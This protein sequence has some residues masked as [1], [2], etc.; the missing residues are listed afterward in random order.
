MKASP[1]STCALSQ[2]LKISS[3]LALAIAIL[4]ANAATAALPYC[5]GLFARGIQTFGNNSYV[6]FDY[7]AQ[8]VNAESISITTSRVETH[9]WSIRKSCNTVVCLATL[10]NMSKPQDK[11]KLTTTS[12]LQVVIPRDKKITLGNDG[13]TEFGE[14]S[15]SEWG[16]GVFS[17]DN[18]VYI[19]DQLNLGYKSSL[20]L[21][22]GE[23]WIRTLNMDVESRID[24]MGE[25][26]V[27]LYFI[28]SF[29]IPLN[30]KLNTNTRNPAQMTIYSYGSA[31]FSV[32]SQTYAFVRANNK[33]LMQHR[34]RITGGVIANIVDLGTE[35]QI[36]HDWPAAKRVDLPTI[37]QASEVSYPVDVT[38]PEILSTFIDEDPSSN[39]ATF[40]AVIR[41]S[42]ENASG[43]ASVVLRSETEEWP[44]EASG[45]TYTID[46][47]LVP[48]ENPFTVYARDNAGNESSQFDLA[49]FWSEPQFVNMTYLDYTY[50]PTLD[51]SGEI[52]TY[53]PPED[54]AL[55]IASEPV[56]L[57][58]VAEGIYRFATRLDLLEGVNRF[59]LEVTTP[60]H[61]LE[62]RLDTFY[63]WPGLN[64]DK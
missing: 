50:E 45:D 46:V 59:R 11:R 26:T 28:N 2:L 49:I 9:P 51:V 1:W 64:P 40:I 41:D 8:I 7:N 63:E 36:A 38:P 44:M 13:I 60:M 47:R 55:S 12:T 37:C 18:N 5:T 48:G 52:H 54:V 19:I 16:T 30:V 34:A 35:S 39:R 53:W 29:T 27:H 6:N 21:P 10:T 25:G 61:D 23:Y 33:L 42:G 14:V 43:I 31:E 17:P 4:F 56:P 32:G 20:R 57:I 24:V 22:A 15:I 58:P 62:Y 3:F